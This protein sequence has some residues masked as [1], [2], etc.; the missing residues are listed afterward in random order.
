[1]LIVL[2]MPLILGGTSGV[3]GLLGAAVIGLVSVT[4]LLRIGLLSFAVTLICWR[5]LSHFPITLDFNSWYFGSSVV[6][7]LLVAA[8]A[9]YGFIVSLGG[10]PAFGAKSP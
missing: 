2:G 9:A 10:H 6:I 4:I 7:L 8:I 1:V 5:V 3:V